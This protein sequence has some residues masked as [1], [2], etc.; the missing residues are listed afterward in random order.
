M[1]GSREATAVR[2]LVMAKAPVPGLAKTRLAVTLGD[3]TAAELAAAALLD[4]LD[5]VEAVAGSDHRLLTL[6]GDLDHAAAGEQLAGRL[7]SWHRVEQR[8]GGFAERLVNAHRDAAALWGDHVVVQIGTDTPQVSGADFARLA[9]VAQGDSR[10]CALGPA[11]D[12]GWWGLATGRPGL[13]DSL[14]DVPMSRADT[15]HLTAQALRRGGA[16]VT[17]LHELTDVDTVADAHAVTRQFP[18]LAF[19]RLFAQVY[20]DDADA[21]RREATR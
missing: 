1:S 14:A 2:V 16:T 9:H 4:T 21:D 11:A 17:L 8:G 10:A 12:G 3:V 18:Q 20:G 6:T 7:D 19:S 15:G 13:A 5:A